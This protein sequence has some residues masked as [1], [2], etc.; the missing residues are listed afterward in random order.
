MLDVVIA[1]PFNFMEHIDICMI[2]ILG[3]HFDDHVYFTDVLLLGFVLIEAVHTV[4]QGFV[5]VGQS[6]YP[7]MKNRQMLLVNAEEYGSPHNHPRRKNPQPGQPIGIPFKRRRAHY[8][9]PP[10]QIILISS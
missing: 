6:A 2:F 9:T 10:L 4:G 1:Q 7:F 3:R 8:C 5:L